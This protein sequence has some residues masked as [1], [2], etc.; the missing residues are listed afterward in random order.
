MKVNGQYFHTIWINPNHQSEVKII[1]QNE[2]PFKFSIKTLRTFDDA[3]LAIK[4]MDVRGA[5]LIGVTAA[6]GLYLGLINI[7]ESN[8]HNEFKL[9]T[10]K[11]ITARPTAVNL[12]FA[13]NLL[14]EALKNTNDLKEAQKLAL[15]TAHNL[16]QKEIE[17]CEKIGDYGLHL[18][19]K[20][21][22]KKPGQTINI[23]THCNAGWLACIDW[24]TATAPIYK[25]HHKGIPV[26][27][28]VDETRPRNQGSKLTAFELQQEGIPHTVIP[29]NAGGHLMQHGKVDIVIVGS[30]RTTKNGDVC[31]KIGTYLKALA[32]KDNEIPFYVALPF[33]SIDLSLA[34]GVKEIPIEKRDADE[35]RFVEGKTGKV[36]VVPDDS[37]IVNYG[38]DVTPSRLVTALITEKGITHASV[39]GIQ[40]LLDD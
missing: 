17:N 8:F 18:I 20:I 6:Y 13:V 7:K 39:D 9:L 31:N 16:K 26:H 36:Q 32:A 34:N 15:E 11:M 10:K 22:E 2:L 35:V 29:D 21:A 5:P 38:F 30:D 25:A 3:F 27:V 33:S 1:N 24:G 23:L 4:E 40:A 12:E 28:W 19:E 14:I 37:P